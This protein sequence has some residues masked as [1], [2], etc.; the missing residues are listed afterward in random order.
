MDAV[1]AVTD[2]LC[3]GGEGEGGEAD[4]GGEEGEA[5]ADDDDGDVAEAG[6]AFVGGDIAAFD[7]GTRPPTRCMNDNRSS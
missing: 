2:E 1:A 6:A 5:M 4:E 3:M 7:N